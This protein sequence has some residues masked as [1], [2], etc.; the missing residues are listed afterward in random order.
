M[1]A[2]RVFLTVTLLAIVT[3]VNFAAALRGYQASM[4]EAEALLNQR[5]TQQFELLDL[6][7]P[8]L[9]EWAERPSRGTT[10]IERSVGL[11]FQWM[12]AERQVLM[13]SQGA[14][15]E[16]V[17]EH[18]P[19]FGKA[20][21]GGYRWHVLLAERRGEQGWM[22][23]AERDDERYRVAES[24][25]V[26]AVLPMVLAVPVLALVIWSLLGFG[27]RP[28]RR[29]AGDLEQREASDLRPLSA[30]ALP[31]ELQRLA[32]SANSLL[33]RLEAA[34]EREKRFAADAAHELRSP[35]AALRIQVENLALRAPE[36]SA[37]VDKL[38]QGIER[39][40]HLVDQ[41][42]ILSRLAP[43]QVG[44]VRCRFR[45]VNV[46][47]LARQLIAEQSELLADK[48]L[49]IAYEG[50]EDWALGDPE[51]LAALLRNLLDNAMKYTPCEGRIRVSSERREDL[52]CLRVIDNGPGIPAEQRERVFDR[53][54]R[55]GGDRHLSG[56]SGCGLGLSIVR[57][58]IDLHQGSIEFCDAPEGQG[59]Q[60]VVCL[61]AAG[62]PSKGQEGG[63]HEAQ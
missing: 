21:F 26:P 53:F 3:L 18:D 24:V 62:A 58:V 32:Q 12:D 57:Q 17:M 2:I 50:G 49:D 9:A 42:L 56:V 27:L 54:Y 30:Q 22:L 10:R 20:N 39:M 41:I 60:V 45:P 40:Q 5:M 23:L 25:I 51:G 47:A 4:V 44:G 29:L 59:L 61:P 15:A 13:R 55:V 43:D 52:L 11:E 16:H 1:K 36:H 46:A 6:S 31:A 63:R 28:I 35:I 34:F 8:T 38:H 7:L 48:A 19:G 37:A 14:P 33:R